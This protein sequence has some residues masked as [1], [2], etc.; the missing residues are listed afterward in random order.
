VLQRID[1]LLGFVVVRVRF[2]VVRVRFVVVRVRFVFLRLRRF[3]S[4]LL[5]LPSHRCRQR[6]RQRAGF[7]GGRPAASSRLVTAAK[8]PT[9]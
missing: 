6:P 5:D 2:V 4:R 1:Q 9:D 3:R 7:A 8:K